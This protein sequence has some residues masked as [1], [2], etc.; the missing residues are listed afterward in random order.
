MR[1]SVVHLGIAS[2]TIYLSYRAN[3]V[4]G[5]SIVQLEGKTNEMNY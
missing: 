2:I 3:S 4:I 1:V 5:S